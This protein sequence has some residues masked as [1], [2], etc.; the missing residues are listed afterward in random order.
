MVEVGSSNLPS[1]TKLYLKTKR[2]AA[3]GFF[4]SAL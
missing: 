4:V 2:L 3:F 1:P